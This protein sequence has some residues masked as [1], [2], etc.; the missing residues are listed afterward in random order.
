M[1][2]VFVLLI[3]AAPVRAIPI[4]PDKYYFDVQFG[5]VIE[6]RLLIMGRPELEDRTTL[7]I[8]PV[9]MIKEGEE[10]ERSFY[11]PDVQDPAEPANWITVETPS[12]EIGPGEEVWVDWKMEPTRYAGCGTNLVALAVTDSPLEREGEEGGVIT[13]RKQLISQ[14]H[15]TMVATDEGICSENTVNLE[16]LAFSIDS[17]FPLFNYDTV[18]FVTRIRNNGNL[19]S[20]S[21]QGYIEVFGLGD[22]ITVDFN[23]EM[24]DIY[25]STTRR[26]D[27]T[28]IDENYP[29]EGNFFEKLLYEISHLRIGRYEARLGVTKNADPALVATASF[30]IIPWRILAVLVGTM[31]LVSVGRRFAGR[32]NKRGREV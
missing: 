22:K 24:L 9:G 14:I 29:H 20:R 16:L 5:T 27:N 6:D 30:W 32:K 23:P 10:H 18:P 21:P 11:L 1:L 12:I 17:R 4:S 28:W 15:L 26:F 13:M 7:Y 31:L 25:P 2:A 8:T 3:V 19:I